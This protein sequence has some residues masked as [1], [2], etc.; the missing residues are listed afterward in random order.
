VF[1]VL[2]ISLITFQYVDYLLRE[3]SSRQQ[4]KWH[5]AAWVIILALFLDGVISGG[6]SKRNIRVAGEWLK[7][8]M[9]AEGKIACN[10]A[11]LEF[12]SEQG[13]KWVAIDET[14]PVDAI[15]ELKKEGYTSFL[16]WIHRKNEK[17]R[18]A[19]DSD[20]ELVLEREFTNRK[21]SSVKLYSVKP[22]RQ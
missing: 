19:V 3:L 7:T 5:A 12:Y 17:L 1:I 14:N 22:G 6:T 15:N 2:L 13:C 4:H 10:E 18:L 8:G 20:T 21:G 16:L 11:R 9:A